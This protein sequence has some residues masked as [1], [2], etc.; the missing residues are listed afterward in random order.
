MKTKQVGCR[1]CL[2]NGSILFPVG[3]EFSEQLI[4]FKTLADKSHRFIS[5]K[6]IYTLTRGSKDLQD[7]RVPST[8]T[9][10]EFWILFHTYLLSVSSLLVLKSQRSITWHL[11]LKK[12]EQTVGQ[13]GISFLSRRTATGHHTEKDRK[14]TLGVMK[15]KTILLGEGKGNKQ[16]R[17]FF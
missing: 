16:K 1:R 12:V 3:L 13:A 7:F 17:I 15:E 2:I 11:S 9:E 10:V 4:S 6:N 5:Q 8:L 14:S